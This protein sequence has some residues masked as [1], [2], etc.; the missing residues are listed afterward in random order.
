MQI[1]GHELIKN[2]RPGK[3]ILP[4]LIG[5][6]VVLYL[7][8]SN[9]DREAYAR[10]TWTGHTTLWIILAVV[11]MCVRDL[12]YMYR[13]KV[14]SGNLISWRR[15]FPVIMLWEFASA[16]TPTMVGG[17]ALA[18]FILNKEKVNMGRSIA[19]VLTTSFLDELFFVLAV[20]LVFVLVGKANLF[21]SLDTLTSGTV[22]DAG[23]IYYFFWLGYIII[24]AYTILV[25]YALFINPRAV[26][27]LLLKIFSLPILRRWKQKAWHTGNDMIIA[28]GEIRNKRASYWLKSFAATIFSWTARYMVINCII[29][30][31]IQHG[32][33]EN[34]IIYA[35]QLVMWII[36]LVSP[37]PGGSGIAEVIFSR[38]LGELIPA[39][40][41]DSLALLWRLIS[42][43][44]YL[45]IGALILPRW[46]KKHVID[47]Q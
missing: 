36:L 2:F 23:G 43:Y 12:A 32:W 22:S 17:T 8:I 15:S 9:F 24:L 19:V 30:A 29:M 42:Y 34:M 37:T 10:I 39:G 26:K 28:S 1:D 41:S 5:L 4:V 40:I 13:I 33:Y 46:V 7:L 45:F 35:R 25:A 44:P 11:M 18:F 38:F 31:F 27:W 21:I 20:P 6:G 16:I 47:K 14:L 3:I